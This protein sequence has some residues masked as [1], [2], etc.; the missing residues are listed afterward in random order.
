MSKAQK[1]TPRRELSSRDISDRM[2][3]K[4]YADQVVSHT[5]FVEYD[6]KTPPLVPMH[7]RATLAQLSPLSHIANEIGCLHE[8]IAS[9]RSVV[10]DR[11]DGMRVE[12]GEPDVHDPFENAPDMPIRLRDILNRL[13]GAHQELANLQYVIDSISI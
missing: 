13:A 5:G 2:A 10:V 11:F 6:G 9:L 4:G 12:V 1:N 8:C 7:G 3:S